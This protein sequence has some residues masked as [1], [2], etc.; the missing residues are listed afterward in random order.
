M[1][2]ICL[3]N[4]K[5]CRARGEEGT[6]AEL[7]AG[8]G[9]PRCVSLPCLMSEVKTGSSAR[10]AASGGGV[11]A[12]FSLALLSGPVQDLLPRFRCGTLLL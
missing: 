12:D 7:Q 10:G 5:P 9:T 11:L 1:C 3:R 6:A 8:G 4:K 2:L